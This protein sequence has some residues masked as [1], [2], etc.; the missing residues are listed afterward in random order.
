MS[1]D[2]EGLARLLPF[3]A[4]AIER[5]PVHVADQ[6]NAALRDGLSPLRFEEDSEGVWVVVLIGGL[7]VAKVDVRHLADP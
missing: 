2:E 4:E 3:L 6:L 1:D 5:Q 7:D